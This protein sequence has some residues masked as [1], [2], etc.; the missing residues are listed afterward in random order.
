[1]NLL[2]NDIAPTI[3]YHFDKLF[4]NLC[5]CITLLHDML[6]G[7]CPQFNA[8]SLDCY[9]TSSRALWKIENVHIYNLDCIGCWL[10]RSYLICQMTMGEIVHNSQPKGIELS[11]R[12]NPNPSFTDPLSLLCPNK[13]VEPSTKKSK[14][15]NTKSTHTKFLT[16]STPPTWDGVQQRYM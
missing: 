12:L 11:D 6:H 16:W 13:H 1:M 2:Q 15:E 5:P 7:W 10:W 8:N 3:N 14:H 4:K 9:I